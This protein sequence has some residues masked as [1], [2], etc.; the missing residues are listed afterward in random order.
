MTNI[1]YSRHTPE[2]SG[3]GNAQIALTSDLGASYIIGTSYRSVIRALFRN[4]NTKVRI[5]EEA[6]KSAR[7]DY[8]QVRGTI[9]KFMSPVYDFEF[10]VDANHWSPPENE[11]EPW[12]FASA[13]MTEDGYQTLLDELRQL[14]AVVHQAWNVVGNNQTIKPDTTKE[15]LDDFVSRLWSSGNGHQQAS[16]K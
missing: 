5:I 11:K 8:A 1:V 6:R 16:D 3:N 10:N 15:V 4:H 2:L 9:E 14:G 13:R 7:H 12:C